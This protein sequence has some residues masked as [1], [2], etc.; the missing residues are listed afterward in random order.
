MR[1]TMI[2]YCR[3]MMLKYGAMVFGFVTLGF[4]SAFAP[5]SAAQ[6]NYLF[7]MVLKKLLVSGCF[8]TAVGC[9]VRFGFML[10]GYVVWKRCE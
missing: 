9:L 10:H 4:L 7:V 8:I 3:E 6:E 2:I 5:A 1:E